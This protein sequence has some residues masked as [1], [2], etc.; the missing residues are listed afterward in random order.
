MR[1]KW[2]ALLAIAIIILLASAKSCLSPKLR[3]AEVPSLEARGYVPLVV[4]TGG[5][6]NWKGVG[7][8]A[9]GDTL[10][11]LPSISWHFTWQP[12]SGWGTEGWVPLVKASD[13]DTQGELDTLAS[14]AA[15]HPGAWW[16]IF[17]EPDLEGQDDTNPQVGAARYEAAYDAI[18]GADPWAKL[19][20]CGTAFSN[21]AWL[22]AFE[23]YLTR[24]VDGVH[25]HGYPC[26][27]NDSQA[28]EDNYWG[29]YDR[30]E[31]ELAFSK[32][33]AFYGYCQSKQSF[34]GKPIW[35]TEFGILSTIENESSYI[36]VRDNVMV[37][38]L[39]YM[40]EN[41]KFARVAWFSDRYAYLSASDLTYS[42]DSLTPLGTTWEAATR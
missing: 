30:Y 6:D 33:N 13:C 38:F 16:L 18:K 32:M 35:L 27:S 37:P 9:S 39:E 11:N 28:C 29:F 41:Q 21:T 24:P 2:A 5:Q 10:Q 12:W 22:D 4:G 15:Q 34:A 17:N 8:A 7:K 42:D 19:L 25:F 20:C 40:D 14:L 23:G 1:I 3:V 36:Y 26:R 31:M